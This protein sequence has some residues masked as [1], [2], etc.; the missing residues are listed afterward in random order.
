MYDCKK[1][2]YQGHGKFPKNN[3]GHCKNAWMWANSSPGDMIT[4]FNS[5][6]SLRGHS[7][8]PMDSDNIVIGQLAI[9]KMSENYSMGNY[10]K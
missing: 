3:C 2:N 9:H 4:L 8:V 5:D 10:K 7:I 6:G 1:H